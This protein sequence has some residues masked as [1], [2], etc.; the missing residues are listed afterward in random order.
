MAETLH[1]TEPLET[2]VH[3][4]GGQVT[5][6][7]VP[8]FSQS[9]HQKKL[10]RLWSRTSKDWR[11]FTDRRVQVELKV[12]RSKVLWSSRSVYVIIYCKCSSTTWR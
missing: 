2:V 5:L 3:T 8:D 6:I 12:Q 4:R 9:S 11:R 7:D 10:L 1:G